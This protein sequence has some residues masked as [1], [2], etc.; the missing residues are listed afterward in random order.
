MMYCPRCNNTHWTIT[1]P[2]GWLDRLA[3]LRLKRP[4]LCIKCERVRLGSI[5]LDLRTS[6]FRKPRRKREENQHGSILKCPS[7]GGVV[8]RVHRKMLE[9][10]LFFVRAYRCIECQTRFR[11]FRAE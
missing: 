9:R 10:A 1:K 3:I 8:R 5:F 7:C 4:F 6:M 2:R 11:T